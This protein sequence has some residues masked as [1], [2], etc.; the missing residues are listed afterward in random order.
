MRRTILSLLIIVLLAIAIIVSLPLGFVLNVSGA[1]Q[2]GIGWLQARG[3]VW[4]GQILGLSHQGQQYGTLSL[5]LQPISLLGGRA[6]Y[7]TKWN[8]PQG[9]GAGEISAFPNRVQIKDMRV[10]V[11]LSDID[12]IQ[13]ILRQTGG[14]LRANMSQLDVTRSGCQAASGTLSTD[15][16]RRLGIVYNRQWPDMTGEIQCEDGVIVLPLSSS[17][18]GGE[19]F[20]IVTRLAMS[21]PSETQIRIEGL[22]AEATLALMEFGFEQ[23]PNSGLVY[24]EI[25]GE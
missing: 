19:N 22:D 14:V 9:N 20:S 7:K 10:N 24:R 13:P 11:S 2:K 1:N 21:G 18:S 4:N 25:L 3:T 15:A 23:S 8:G 17:T 5:K 16:M 6:S 12:G